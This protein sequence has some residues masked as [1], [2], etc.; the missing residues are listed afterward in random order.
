M[1]SLELANKLNMKHRSIYLI[2]NKNIDSFKDFGPIGKKVYKQGKEGG[3]P[4][5]Y[6]LLN[7]YH[8]LFLIMLLKNSTEG[9]RIKQ[10]TLKLIIE[11][12][13]SYQKC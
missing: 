3:R 5:D 6:F 4:G 11:K 7:K 13:R 2:I 8:E 12:E 10:D 9:I 1:N